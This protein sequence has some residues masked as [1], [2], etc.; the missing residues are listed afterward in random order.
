[1][2]RWLNELC[3]LEYLEAD[4]SKQGKAVR[5]A[6]ADRA[7]KHDLVLDLLSPEDLRR[8]VSNLAT[9]PNFANRGGGVLN[10]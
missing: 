10:H 9:S 1:V 4:S 5:Y 2:R 3:E 6:L 7:P 8:S